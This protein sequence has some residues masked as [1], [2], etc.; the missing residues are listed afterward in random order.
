MSLK[1]DLLKHGRLV[2]RYE[3][4]VKTWLESLSFHVYFKKTDSA[5]KVSKREIVIK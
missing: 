5:L 1:E 4:K 2:N 3:K